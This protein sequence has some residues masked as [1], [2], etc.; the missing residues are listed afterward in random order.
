MP[1][2]AL[3]QEPGSLERGLDVPIE[4]R[5]AAE[6]LTFRG[7]WITPASNAELGARYPSF[8]VTPGDRSRN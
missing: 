5:P 6:L 1:F 2:Y 8:D 4:E 3:V 7:Q